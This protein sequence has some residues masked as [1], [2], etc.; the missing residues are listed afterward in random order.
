VAFSL[1]LDNEATYFNL[2]KGER[3]LRRRIFWLLFV[4][5]RYLI[6]LIVDMRGI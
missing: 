2:P 3:E 1:G 5:E 4:T 6:P